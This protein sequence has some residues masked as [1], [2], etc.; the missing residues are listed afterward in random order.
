MNIRYRKVV[1]SPPFNGAEWWESEQVSE[2]KVEARMNELAE[3]GP[4]NPF[5][6]GTLGQKWFAHAIQVQP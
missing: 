1:Q 3:H 4:D 6:T 5:D 2:D